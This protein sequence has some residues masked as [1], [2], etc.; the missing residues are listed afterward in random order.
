MNHGRPVKRLKIRKAR[1][2]AAANRR[3]YLGLAIGAA[4]GIA[5]FA[6]ALL[7]VP[8]GSPSQMVKAQMVHATAT[9]PALKTRALPTPPAVAST[10]RPR[11]PPTAEAP[12]PTASAQAAAQPTC[13][14][15]GFDRLSAFP[16][17]VTDQMVDAPTNAAAASLKT[18]AQIPDGIKALDEKKVSVRGYMLPMNYQEGLATDF[19]ILRNQSMC[20]YGVIPN[21]TEWVNVR[22]I[23]KGVKPIMDQPVTVSGRFHVGDVRENGSLVGIYRLDAEQL[24]GPT[25]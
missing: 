2:L 23:G 25:Q 19:L 24:I 5:L 22:M 13:L 20:C 16:F 15:V 9:G 10:L 3:A 17:E 11:S 12:A 1:A 8:I 4:V 21:I 7:V 18:L 14:S 6:M